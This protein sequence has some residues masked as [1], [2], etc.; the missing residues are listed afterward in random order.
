MC[1][2][3]IQLVRMYLE[4]I[5]LRAKNVCDEMAFSASDTASGTPLDALPHIFDRFYRVDS[6]RKGGGRQVTGSGLAIVQQIIP[7]HSGRI[8][9]R[10]KGA[11]KACYV[12]LPLARSSA[13]VPDRHR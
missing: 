9:V 3:L 7:A 2:Q 5:R 8:S 10:S 6:A 13:I 4:G 1:Y 11:G 12:F